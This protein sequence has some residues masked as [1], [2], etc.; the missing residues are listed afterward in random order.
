MDRTAWAIAELRRLAH[1]D[2]PTDLMTQRL[3]LKLKMIGED[4]HY[5]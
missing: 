5:G 3:R 4:Q 2:G 1:Q